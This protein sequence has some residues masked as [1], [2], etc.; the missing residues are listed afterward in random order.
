MSMEEAELVVAAKLKRSI[1][2]LMMKLVK[3]GMLGEVLVLA[4]SM[5]VLEYVNTKNLHKTEGFV[6]LKILRHQDI[7][8]RLGIVGY[9][10]P[11][12]QEVMVKGALTDNTETYV[13]E[14]LGLNLAILES[15]DGNTRNAS[16]EKL[17]KFQR[18]KKAFRRSSLVMVQSS[19]FSAV[20]FGAILASSIL[21]CLETPHEAI[22]GMLS[23]TTVCLRASQT[24]LL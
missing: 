22:E 6:A 7:S 23:P 10:E 19:M 24:K 8:T 2:D 14:Y 9:F 3:G 5:G 17:S 20:M 13:D 4:T 1:E 18:R 11:Y 15:H 16:G 21:L 12:I